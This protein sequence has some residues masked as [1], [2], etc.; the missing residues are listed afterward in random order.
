M[1]DTK[2]HWNPTTY[3]NNFCNN[4]HYCDFQEIIATPLQLVLSFA[5]KEELLNS[6]DNSSITVFVL[7]NNNQQASC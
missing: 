5:G 2:I 4:Y 7:D 1:L 6:F 3:I